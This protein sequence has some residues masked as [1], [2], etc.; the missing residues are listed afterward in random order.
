MIGRSQRCCGASASGVDDDMTAMRFANTAI[1]RKEP[2]LVAITAAFL[3]AILVLGL[4]PD[5]LWPVRIGEWV[6]LLV[7]IA[8]ISAVAAPMLAWS[9]EVIVDP[10]GRR[11]TSRH[12]LLHR[13]VSEKHSPFADFTAAVVRLKLDRETRAVTSPG[14]GGAKVATETRTSR[15]FT[16]SLLRAGTTV[17]I[18]GGPV[19]VPNHALDLPV[20]DDKDP[21]AQED[22]ARKLHRLGGWPAL[23]RD[24]ALVGSGV[25]GPDGPAYTVR[26]TAEAE[27]A[28]E[29]R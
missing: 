14:S 16:L 23:R 11:V 1:L 13:V 6:P 5:P 29:A 7:L 19:S 4:G 10:V 24:Y 20:D 9:Q 27:S 28:I 26:T 2:L 18:G 22:L 17:M 21:L 12:R 8:L 25:S 15:R 3:V